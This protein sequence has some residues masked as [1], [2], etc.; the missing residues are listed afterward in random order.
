MPIFVQ[1]KVNPNFVFKKLTFSANPYLYTLYKVFVAV[2]FLTLSQVLFWLFNSGLFP[3]HTLSEAFSIILG[4]LHF[5]TMVVCLVL[6]PYIVFT[7]LPTPLQYKRYYIIACNV[8]YYIALSILLLANFIDIIL[9]RFTFR[10]MTADIFNF[11]GVGG[12][13]DKLIPQFFRDFWYIAILYAAA[14]VLFIWV[15]KRVRLKKPAGKILN[16]KYYILHGI[17][18]IVFIG[19]TIIGTRGGMQ[20]RPMQ[21][22]SAGYY[23]SP[24][25]IPLVVNSPFSIVRTWQKNTITETHYFASEQELNAVYQ[26]VKHYIPSAQSSPENIV[27]LILE[28]FSSEY[29]GG[30]SGKESYTPFLDSLIQKSLAYRGLANCKRSMDGIPAVLA[31]MPLLMRDSYITSPYSGNHLNAIP[32]LLK[33]KGY[34][35]SFFH[36]GTNGTM[37]FDAFC[38]A[39]GI[40]HYYGRREYNNEKDYDG[41]WGIFD[42]PFLQYVAKTIT[43]NSSSK[44]C[45]VVFTLSSHH[46]YTLPSQY[47]NTFKQGTLPIHPT[48]GYTDMALR[49]FFE[50]AS[51]TD[52]YNNTLF[53]IT[54][55]HAAGQSTDAYHKNLL[56]MYEVPII[57]YHP[58]NILKGSSE[59]F[60]QQAD[61]MPSVLQYVGYDKPF[62]CFGESVFDTTAVHYNIT[63]SN[64]EYQLVK[65]DY[66][67]RF[68]GEKTTQFYNIQKDSLL[69]NNLEGQYPAIEQ[70][71]TLFLKAVIQQYNNRLK[72]NKNFVDKK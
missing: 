18:F 31:S 14:I 19:I 38:K 50:T 16:I 46:P 25:N 22:I 24:E 69:K 2:L 51:K 5:S 56:G 53:I 17:Y 48:I 32:N 3:S 26:P 7:L 44:F 1:S 63:F 62:V 43:Q 54:A 70:P 10:R 45:A 52:W 58:K 15:A 66:L 33:E 36:G 28:S 60:V 57:F 23:T 47:K 72:N 37:G 35:T 68:D 55:D 64:E 6:L 41:K 65:N 21:I 61:I 39:I 71:M 12:D 49:K 30:I 34:H 42:E 4:S 40:E 9:Y 29:I 13:F 20:L 11:L 59:K 27:I 8:Y 67:I